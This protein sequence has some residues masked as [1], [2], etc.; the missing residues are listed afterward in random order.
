VISSIKSTPLTVTIA[1][2]PASQLMPLA[3]PPFAVAGTTVLF[4]FTAIDPYGNVAPG[5]T[6]NRINFSST[7]PHAMLLTTADNSFSVI[8][9]TAGT[10]SLT[11]TESLTF[12]GSSNASVT[13]TFQI[14]IIPAAPYKLIFADKTGGRPVSFTV[15]A[16]SPL[17]FT[18]EAI[19]L[20]GNIATSYRGTVHFRS[21]DSAALLPDDYTFTAADNGKHSFIATFG[22]TG[23]LSLTVED[24][25]GI[26]PRAVLA[27][28]QIVTAD[29]GPPRAI[30]TV[31]ILTSQFLS[32]SEGPLSASSGSGTSQSSASGQASGSS[33][34]PQSELLTIG[35]PLPSDFAD[36]DIRDMLSLSAVNFGSGLASLLTGNPE[37]VAELLPQEESSLVPVATLIP[38]SRMDLSTGRGVVSGAPSSSNA[39]LIRPEPPVPEELPNR[40]IEKNESRVE[41][42]ERHPEP[43]PPT[44]LDLL[45][46]KPI[47]QNDELPVHD[48]D[49]SERVPSA[50]NESFSGS[51][52]FGAEILRIK[53]TGKTPMFSDEV[54]GAILAVAVIQAIWSDIRAN[55]Q[56]LSLPNDKLW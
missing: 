22:T 35:L 44:L 8:F 21:S 6:I 20:Y 38:S 50:R 17:S 12:T 49:F 46:P 32:P 34:D 36:S 55:R 53:D 29:S 11:Y 42:L 4:R 13:G 33:R 52:D 19:D 43:S 27:V 1:P 25:T 9:K 23:N 10:Q 2:A 24:A 45:L 51:G 37:Q 56:T 31:Q 14:M 40:G 5:G 39:F 16:G 30:T 54:S 3:L 28:T 26:I 18:V 48:N 41:S 15:V 47:D 7:D